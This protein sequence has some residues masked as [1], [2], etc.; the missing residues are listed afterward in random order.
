[1]LLPVSVYLIPSFDLIGWLL[2]F[3]PSSFIFIS[4]CGA[5]VVLV[6]VFPSRLSCTVYMNGCLSCPTR[7][8]C[9]CPLLISLLFV[10]CFLVFSSESL[11]GDDVLCRLLSRPLPSVCFLPCLF[12][13]F[14]ISPTVFVPGLF[15]CNFVYLVT[16][17]FVADQLKMWDKQQ[18]VRFC[19]ILCHFCVLF[20]FVF[21][22][23]R[24]IRYGF[25]SSFIILFHLNAVSFSSLRV[26]I[27]LCV[28]S[29]VLALVFM[30]GL[31]SAAY[32]AASV[33]YPAEEPF[34]WLPFVCFFCLCFLFFFFWSWRRPLL[35]TFLSVL[36]CLFSLLI[37]ER[38]LGLI[39]LS[40]VYL[41]TTAGFVADQLMWNEQQTNKNNIICLNIKLQ[42][43]FCWC[44]RVPQVRSCTMFVLV[45]Y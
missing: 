36:F 34:M 16:T 8:I 1:M 12:V 23:Y 40:S 19:V 13:L 17:G 44:S 27:S 22:R 3:F 31:Y 26:F 14:W 29:V 6:L 9:G 10:F 35:T 11:P 30:P 41:V 18:R 25:C 42:L 28:A 4:L 33:A 7:I 32:R 37:S 45:L 2:S 21:L 20:P 24:L 38:I 15:C 5:L 39:W 43:A